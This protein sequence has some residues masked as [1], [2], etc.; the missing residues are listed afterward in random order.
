M[1]VSF[2]D[3]N[4]WKGA[5]HRGEGLFPANFVT[6]DLTVVVEPEPIGMSCFLLPFFTLSYCA[7]FIKCQHHSVLDKPIRARSFQM[8]V[9][10]CRC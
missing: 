3:P 7:K 2:R 5:N 9:I 1:C 6:A 10:W 4:W 8:N